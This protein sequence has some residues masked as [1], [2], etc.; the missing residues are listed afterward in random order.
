MSNIKPTSK[1]PITSPMKSP[2]SQ[3]CVVHPGLRLCIGCGRSLDEI[4]RWS[5][6][7]GAERT[8]IMAQLPARLTAINGANTAPA[9]A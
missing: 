2:C 7:T 8:R 5:A 4:G 6:M 9:S 3:I 1:S